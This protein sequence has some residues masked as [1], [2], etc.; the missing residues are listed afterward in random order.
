M[1]LD[2][3]LE[4]VDATA[5]ATATGAA[6][7]GDVVDLGAEPQD[8]G[9]GRGMYWV[10]QITTAVTSGGAATV[11]FK[12]G[13]DAAAAIT[14][15]TMTVHVDS[16]AIAK[17]TLAAGYTRVYPMPLG[18]GNVYERYLGVTTTVAT[19]ALTAGAFNSFL[20]YDPSYWKS[21]ADATN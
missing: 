4:F 5:I 2:E 18:V 1:I 10:I 13:S 19:A 17:A 15:A 7:A 6:L 12:L 9:H 20:T 8:F 16:G 14:P 3:L 21:Y 11:Q